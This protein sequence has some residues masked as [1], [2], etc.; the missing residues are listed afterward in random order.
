MQLWIVRVIA[1]GAVLRGLDI[2][3]RTGC[4]FDQRR[5]DDCRLGLFQLQPT[6]FDLPTD[7]G[8]KII[9]NTAPHQSVAE[10]TMGRFIRHRGVQIE[11]TKNH[12]IQPNFQGALQLRIAQPVPLANQQ[13][14][15]QNQR[16]VALRS[17]P[18]SLQTTLQDR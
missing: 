16:I 4:A 13:A 10:P 6:G 1:L 12:E 8:Q 17:D 3:A 7:F 14:F 5:I 15:E 18:R 9:V 11:P 2:R